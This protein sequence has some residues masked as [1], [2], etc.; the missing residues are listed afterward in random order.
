MGGYG[1]DAFTLFLFG[2]L[3]VVFAIQ[4]YRTRLAKLKYK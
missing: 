3:I 2:A 1:C 4:Q